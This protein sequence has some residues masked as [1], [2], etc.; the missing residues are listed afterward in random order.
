M[1]LN[2]IVECLTINPSTGE[3]S[4]NPSVISSTT[5]YTITATNTGGTTTA[6]VSITVNDVIPSA[7]TYNANPYTLTKD[8]AMTPDTPS[9]SGGAVESWSITP[10]L[11]TGLTFNTSTGE[12]SGIPLQGG[13]YNVTITATNSFGEDQGV[14]SLS[15]IERSRLESEFNSIGVNTIKLLFS[16]LLRIDGINFFSFNQLIASGIS[17]NKEII[18]SGS[19]R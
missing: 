2:K 7:I 8:S 19:F 16:F 18:F 9:V 3:L 4:G 14:L 10:S 5:A 1:P 13:T 15:I 6:T 17:L 11:P 12:I